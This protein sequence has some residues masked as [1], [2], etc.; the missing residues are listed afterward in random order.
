MQHLNAEPLPRDY[1]VKAP[2]PDSKKVNLK[3]IFKPSKDGIDYN[4][5]IF[6]HGLGDTEA[7]FAKLGSDMNIPQTAILAVRAPF[8]IPLI[9]DAYQWF[10]SFD[11]NTGYLLPPGAPERMRGLME[12]RG[13]MDQLIDHMIVHCGF[14][15]RNIYLFGF[16]NGG[17]V[18]M[19][20]LLFGKARQLGGVISIGG[21]LLEEEHGSS[22][23]KEP[24]NG[25]I[26]ITRGSK[27]ESL[28][29]ESFIRERIN[30]IEKQC[31]SSTRVEQ[32]VIQGKGQMMPNSAEEWKIINL[33]L[34]KII[35]LRNK[36]ME[37]MSDVYTVNM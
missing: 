27:D 9:E 24:Y 17:T 25:H 36:E 16:L 30:A 18:A 23:V 11:M 28:G 7:S 37:S 29:S 13:R 34:S 35:R 14:K 10:P 19:D 33:F 20:T 12:T 3:F 26:L 4:L 22:K 31:S 6:L 32:H 5:I 8:P 15:Q 2:L 21:Y 1:R